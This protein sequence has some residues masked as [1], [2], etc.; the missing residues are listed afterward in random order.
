MDILIETTRSSTI[1][2]KDRRGDLFRTYEKKGKKI[3][4]RI[5]L[6]CASRKV[7]ILNVH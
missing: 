5:G 1:N 3:S 2:N 4:P 7:E 6:F